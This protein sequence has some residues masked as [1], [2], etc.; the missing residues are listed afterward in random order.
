MHEGEQDVSSQVSAEPAGVGAPSE[1]SGA[2][3]PRLRAQ[4][5]PAV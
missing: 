2:P 5:Q 1:A 3:D 4:A